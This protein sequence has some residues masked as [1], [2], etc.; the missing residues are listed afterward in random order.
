MALRHGDWKL[1]RQAK[2]KT[3]LFNLAKDPYEKKDLAAA[4][5]AKRKELET[6]LAA[7]RAKDRKKIPADLEKAVR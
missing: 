1:V 2:D 6:L 4:E 3:E 7:E 5:P